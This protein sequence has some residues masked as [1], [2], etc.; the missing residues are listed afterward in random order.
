[1]IGAVDVDLRLPGRGD[2][3]PGWEIGFELAAVHA[4]GEVEFNEHVL[5]V[6]RA[7]ILT[8]GEAREVGFMRLSLGDAADDGIGGGASRGWGLGAWGREDGGREEGGE[9]KDGGWGEHGFW[10]LVLEKRGLVLGI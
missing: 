9:E 4:S 5:L 8:D 7:G 10:V 2:G 1:M 6:G 3:I